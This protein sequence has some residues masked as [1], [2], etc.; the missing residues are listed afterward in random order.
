M[1]KENTMNTKN[2][3]KKNFTEYADAGSSCGDYLVDY[4][5]GKISKVKFQAQIFE[6]ARYMD[7]DVRD[8]MD[9]LIKDLNKVTV[10]ESRKIAKRVANKL[11]D[12]WN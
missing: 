10:A 4:I 8:C 3:L 9:E 5:Q 7:V 12:C 2:R 11:W 6:Y 1:M